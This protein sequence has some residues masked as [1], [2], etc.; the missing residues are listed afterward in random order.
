MDSKPRRK[1]IQSPFGPALKAIMQKRSLSH[2][3]VAQMA[4]VSVSTTHDWVTGTSVPHDLAAVGRLAIA[5]GVRFDVLVLG[6]PTEQRDLSVEDFFEE[7][8]A[9]Q[10]TGIFKIERVKKL[11]PKK[12]K[13][14]K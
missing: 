5:M 14:P 6:F 1:K 2:R 4:G 8:P 3:Q 12:S 9:E 7:I 13:L 10:L 11:I